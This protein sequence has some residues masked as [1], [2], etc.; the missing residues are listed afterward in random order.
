MGLSNT[1]RGRAAVGGVIGVV[2][3]AVDAIA[4]LIRFVLNPYVAE[5]ATGG[6]F[7]IGFAGLVGGSGL[8]ALL[9]AG[10]VVAFLLFSGVLVHWLRG[11]VWADAAM[12]SVI[13]AAL[14]V[15]SVTYTVWI[16]EPL[17]HSGFAAAQIRTGRLYE[18]GRGGALRDPAS[19]R[20]GTAGRPRLAALRRN[21]FSAR[22]SRSDCPGQTS[23]SESR[24]EASVSTGCARLR[25]RG[26]ARPHTPFTCCSEKAT[27]S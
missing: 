15:V 3:F 16:C 17:G 7:W 2:V 5:R 23:R 10:A 19:P 27:R 14:V 13:V 22:P 20:I 25:P 4:T 26:T 8:F 18:E 6:S 9:G 1:A 12:A 21:S 11:R 24:S